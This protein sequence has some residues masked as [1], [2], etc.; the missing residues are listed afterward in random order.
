[1]HGTRRWCSNTAAREYTH[2]RRRV[3]VWRHPKSR[4]TPQPNRLSLAFLLRR[5]SAP[6]ENK[7]PCTSVYETGRRITKND[8]VFRCL[9]LYMESTTQCHTGC[10]WQTC[11]SSKRNRWPSS[12]QVHYRATVARSVTSPRLP[13]NGIVNLRNAN[14][15]LVKTTCR[16]ISALKQ[17]SIVEPSIMI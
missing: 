12:Q 13:E 7:Y 11:Y 14:C 10:S 9:P 3:C 15:R 4:R 5:S 6:F 16:L 8:S 2:A 1:L 17:S